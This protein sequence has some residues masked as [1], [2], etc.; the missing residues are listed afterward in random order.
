MITLKNISK[1]YGKGGGRV[2]AL[3]DINLAIQ[4]G[5]F[6]ALCGPSGSGKSTLL[7]IMGLLD[8]PSTGQYLFQGRDS[9][10]LGD[11]E[12]S[13][14]RNSTIG[15]VFQSF[16]LLPRL[17][18]L[19]N[20]CLPLLYAGRRDAP[21]LARKALEQVDLGHRVD[22]YPGELS[23]GEQQRV[24]IARALVKKPKLILADEPTGNL[25][26]KTGDQ[27]LA[28]LRN[29]QQTDG[30]TMVIVTHDLK[31]AQS[32]GRVITTQDG[33]ILSDERA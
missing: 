13:R 20:V 5:E 1:T 33:A 21:E 25:D 15:F 8:Q 17:T 27:T 2:D 30:V 16:Y 22:H 7:H 3:K 31:I 28:L 11:R 9:T 12:K 19:Q 6:V 26:T 29:I 4:A 32:A 24:A 14:I 10:D 23:G 18:A